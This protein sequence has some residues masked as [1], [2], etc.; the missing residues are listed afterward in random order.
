MAQFIWTEPDPLDN[1][2]Q[3]RSI[4]VTELQDAANVK[5]AELGQP[6]L[7]FTDQSI[8]QL[9]SL[10]AIDELKE[11]IE[12][13]ATD[14]GYSGIS[15][16][17]LLGRDWV[18]ITKKYGKEVCHYPI[19]NDMRQVLNAIQNV[20]VDLLLVKHCINTNTLLNTDITAGPLTLGHTLESTTVLFPTADDFHVYSYEQIPNNYIYKHDLLNS[21]PVLSYSFPSTIVIS[22]MVVDGSYLWIVYRDNSLL[23]PDKTYWRVGRVNKSDFTNFT[24]IFTL[25]YN[26]YAGTLNRYRWDHVTKDRNNFYFGGG[27]SDPGGSLPNRAI[28]CVTDYLGSATPV[29][30]L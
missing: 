24:Y 18:E 9:F 16:P 6:D 22:T 2:A 14:F 4:F 8:G 1:T 28:A 7:V 11:A 30:K 29:V 27:Y 5:R 26:I 12:N 23:A 20:P 10:T 3:T 13:L 25:P 15:D 21:S 17:N 19:I